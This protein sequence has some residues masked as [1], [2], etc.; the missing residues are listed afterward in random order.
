[1]EDYTPVP[2]FILLIPI[3]SAL[4]VGTLW[5]ASPKR[6]D[7]NTFSQDQLII[8]KPQSSKNNTPFI[9]ARG[10][11]VVDRQTGAVTMSKNAN[12]RFTPASA[13]K[14]M[15]ALVALE[16]YEL[17]EILTAENETLPKAL[18]GLI[19]GEKIA[20]RE[21][22]YGLLLNSGN[23]AAWTIAK[24]HPGGMSGFVEQMNKMAQHLGLVN[25]S[26]V[27]P[28]GLGDAG[29]FTTALDLAKLTKKALDNPTFRT[30]V[31]TKDKTVYDATG[32]IVH[33]LSNLNKLLWEDPRVLGVKTGFTERA[34]GVLVTYFE[35]DW[36]DFIIIIFDSDD[37]FADTKQLI[38]DL[39]ENPGVNARD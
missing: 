7:A 2:K 26:F 12:L 23:D 22:L 34:G 37:R 39:A 32:N 5:I 13:T 35:G 6:I 8:E 38:S 16:N 14:I 3:I 24:H 15:T 18:M 1:M 28:A 19:P 27:D 33:N 30:I 20:V 17:D 31:R 11:L 25:T 29:N 9:S 36:S 4:L 10:F 21:L